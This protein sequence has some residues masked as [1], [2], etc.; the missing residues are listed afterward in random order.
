MGC[1]DFVCIISLILRKFGRR[2]CLENG[3]KMERKQEKEG[4]QEKEGK[5]EGQ[6]EKGRKQVIGGR[7]QCS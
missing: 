3:G 7:Y 6:K 1:S 4:N 2:S 5:N